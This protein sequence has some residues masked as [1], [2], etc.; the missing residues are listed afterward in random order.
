MNI[1]SWPGRLNRLQQSRLFKIMAS[2]LV[3]LIT[4]GTSIA[5]TVAVSSRVSTS[6]VTAE[7]MPEP[8]ADAAPGNEQ[9]TSSGEAAVAASVKPP[10]LSS[11]GQIVNDILGAKQSSTGFVVGALIAMSI[12]LV[13]IWLGLGLTYL[14]LAIVGSSSRARTRSSPSPAT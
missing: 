9:P 2:V 8:G 5:Y 14:A 3:V 12:S 6:K 1:R 4:I 13:I 10:V 11:T 7:D